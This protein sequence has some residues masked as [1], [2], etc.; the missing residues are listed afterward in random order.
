M[1]LPVFGVKVLSRCSANSS[2][3]PLFF[4][5]H[6]QFYLLNGGLWHTGF[7]RYLVALHNQ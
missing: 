6:V 7:L 1:P 3:F 2:A 5:Y 4:L